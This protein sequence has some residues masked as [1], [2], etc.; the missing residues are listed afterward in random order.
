MNASWNIFKRENEMLVTRTKKTHQRGFLSLLGLVSVA[1]NLLG[2]LLA[3]M[4]CILL[5]LAVI[6]EQQS[7]ILLIMYGVMGSIFFS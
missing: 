7:G 1:I 6:V 2:K 5:A 4:V 3:V